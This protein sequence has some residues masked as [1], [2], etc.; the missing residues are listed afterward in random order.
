[1]HAL[2][3]RKHDVP[4]AGGV[5][6][7]PE[8]QERVESGSRDATLLQAALGVT[9][10]EFPTV[11]FVERHRDRPIFGQME[12]SRPCAEYSLGV[13]PWRRNSWDLSPV[14]QECITTLMAAV[15]PGGDFVH[16][17]DS[18]TYF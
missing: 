2:S 8:I 7:A 1:V 12:A 4:A 11:Q 6:D 9:S 3:C 17:Q 15:G 14:S 13:V 10:Q 18:L 5:L 16:K